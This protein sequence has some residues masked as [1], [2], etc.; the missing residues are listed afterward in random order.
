MH[1]AGAPA[2]P[3]RR[4]PSRV[5]ALWRWPPACAGR[6]LQR[7]SRRNGGRL[8]PVKCQRAPNTYPRPREPR[9]TAAICGKPCNATSRGAGFARPPATV[10]TARRQS[11]AVT[12][13]I[14]FPGQS[15]LIRCCQPLYFDGAGSCTAGRGTPVA[16]ATRGLA[17]AHSENDNKKRGRNCRDGQPVAVMATSKKRMDHQGQ[18]VQQPR[19]CVSVPGR[20]AAAGDPAHR[21]RATLSEHPT[22][23]GGPR[24]QTPECRLAPLCLRMRP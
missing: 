8:S 1:P 3:S 15:Q 5:R 20:T 4:G 7:R 12:P 17:D 10:M 22:P 23:L 19:G 24:A 18:S 14:A 21:A 13:R 11:A 16:T 2:C 6:V 9:P